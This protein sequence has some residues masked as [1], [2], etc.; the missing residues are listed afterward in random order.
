MQLTKHWAASLD[1]YVIDLAWSSDGTRLAAASGSGPI[2][3]F[4][5]KDGN[6]VH[7]LPGHTDGTNTIAW[8]PK[9]EASTAN[10]TLASGGQD[11]AV[12]FWDVIA[13]QHTTTAQLGTGWVEHLAWRPIT[14]SSPPS[15]HCERSAAISRA[16]QRL[17][18][19]EIAFAPRN[20]SGGKL[21]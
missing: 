2:S 20:G 17:G 13:G 1:D 4:E 21:T 11:G 7:E 10:S 9:P 6:R 3:V 19:S 5:G 12:K 18:S 15:R 8:Q 14:H 16:S